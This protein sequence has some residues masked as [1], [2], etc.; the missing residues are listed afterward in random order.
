VASG[1]PTG[2][3]SP[4]RSIPADDKKLRAKVTGFDVRKR[5]PLNEVVV[6]AIRALCFLASSM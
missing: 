2:P 6:P 1:T 5:S 3:S 4:P